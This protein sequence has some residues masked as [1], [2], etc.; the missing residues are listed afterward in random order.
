[1]PELLANDL[2]GTGLGVVI[3]LL[4]TTASVALLMRLTTRGI[5]RTGGVR[6]ED[7]DV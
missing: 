6:E 3:V 1:M 7:P 2:M 4:I 5:G